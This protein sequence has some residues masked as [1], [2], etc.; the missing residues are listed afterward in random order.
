LGVETGTA[1]CFAPLAADRLQRRPFASPTSP[2]KTRVQ[3]FCRGASGRFSLR[4]RRSRAIATGCGVCGYKTA[5]GRSK[6]PNRDPLGEPGFEGLQTGSG[7]QWV[8]TLPT[9]EILQG[10]N[11]YS[12]VDN[13]P[14]IN[15]DALGLIDIPPQTPPP[16]PS[17]PGCAAAKK[18]AATAFKAWAAAPP[19]PAKDAAMAVLTAAIAAE[20]AACSPPPSSPNSPKCKMPDNWPPPH[21]PNTYNNYGKPPNLWPAVPP[22]VIIIITPWPGNPVFGGL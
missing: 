4:R 7:V 13:Q 20:T 16:G 22:V 15:I 12:F 3:D 6:W 19:G 17:S 2:L 14:T 21:P 1:S 5:S 11:S 9:G 8:P 18:A 10:P